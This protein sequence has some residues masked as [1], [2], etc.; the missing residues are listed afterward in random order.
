LG[1]AVNNPNKNFAPQ[2]GIAWD[3][4]KSGKTVIRA[5]IGLFYENSIW[6]NIL[7]DRP[8]REPAG[9]FLAM[10][11]VCTAG[12]APAGGVTLPDGTVVNPT[13][14]GL[15]IGQVQ[16]QIGALQAQYQAAALKA[17]PQGNPVFVG[18][19]LEDGI[20]AT[21]TNLF[22]PDYKTP[23]SVQMNFGI[24]HEIRKGMVFTADYLRNISTHTLLAV[25]TNH[26]GDARYL[27]VN[28]ALAAINATLAAH[29]P[30]CPT[31]TGAGA[32]S[33]AAVTCYLVMVPTASIADFASKGL[34][35][36][37]SN[38]GGAPCPACAFG[39][40]NSSLG[41]NQML[42]PIGRSVL[43]ALQLSL[44]EDV[45]NPFKGV[46]YLNLVVSYELSRYVSQAQDSDFINNA[47]D[48]NNPGK[49]IGPDG[50]DRRHQISFGGIMELPRSFRLGIISHFYSP[51]PQNLT[52]QTTGTP[53]GIF[54]TDV[55][56]DGTGDGA[57]PNGS[58]G[59]FGDI[60]PGTNL[61]SFGR[62]VTPSNLNNVIANYNQNFAGKPTPAGQAL[63][64]ANL[65]TPAQL[66]ALGAVMPQISPA[67]ANQAGDG[68]LRA[69][70]FSLNWTY[71]VKERLAIQPGVT[72]F[73]VLNF[74]NFDAPKNTLSGVLSTVGT[75][76]SVGTANGTPG[77]Q[78]NN[79]RIGLGSGVF[80]LG[81][82]RVIEFNLKLSF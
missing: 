12:A 44:K 61:G 57:L 55:T 23:R 49:F 79:L 67:P 15:P 18:T 78:P 69:L 65:F 3:P 63:L 72:L 38:N 11:P 54:V 2:L 68:W 46:P 13:F 16:G 64:T 9:L 25:D 31:A 76:A 20:N 52:L 36:G 41:T 45:R 53:G 4:S 66:T 81:S 35:S 40:V 1:N 73:N 29:A 56:G 70:D 22:A 42:F 10:Q 32:S 7:F 51:L 37:N 82:P 60:L 75:P 27:N 14:C 62:D 48:S 26:V 59:G 30:A 8:A 58:N 28:A 50:L 43:N 19:N 80:G 34:D 33:Q 6:N 39:G 17:G 77:E 71:K 47:W 5:G 24:Q 74:V 21:G